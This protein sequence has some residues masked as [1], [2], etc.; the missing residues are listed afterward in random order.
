MADDTI[1]Y[2]VTFRDF[3]FLQGYMARRVFSRNRSK[4]GAALGGVVLCAIFLVIAIVIN[5]NPYRVS[6]SLAPGVRYPLSFYLVLICCLLAAIL[7]LFPAVKLRLK[8]LRM[9]VSDNGPFLGPTK[10]VI[11]PDGLVIDRGVLRILCTW[12][13][14]VG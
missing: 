10:L 9:Q 13:Y 2:E 7:C 12:S 8:T 4:Y 3:Q 14:R 11:E 5:I 6:A 1:S